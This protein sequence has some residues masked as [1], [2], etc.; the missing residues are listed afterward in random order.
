VTEVIEGPCLQVA[1]QTL[2]V[3]ALEQIFFSRGGR[4]A[5]DDGAEQQSAEERLEAVRL[6]TAS[7]TSASLRRTHPRG[8]VQQRV[9]TPHRRVPGRLVTGGQRDQHPPVAHPRSTYVAARS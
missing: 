3:A 4:P 5:A 9:V 7:S 6:W 1:G 8:G 2:P